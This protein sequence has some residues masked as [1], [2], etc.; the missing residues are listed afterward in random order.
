MQ[1]PN[2]DKEPPVDMLLRR[3]R[4]SYE[5]LPPPQQ[6]YVQCVY[7]AVV[8]SGML[9]VGATMVRMYAALRAASEFAM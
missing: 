8:I 2:K 5:A 1:G 7:L 9:S 4:E 3:A 6:F